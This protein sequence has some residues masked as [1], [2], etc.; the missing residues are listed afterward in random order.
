[1]VARGGIL[2]II[3]LIVNFVFST[4]AHAGDDIELAGD[5]IAI[6][7]PIVAGATSL[8]KDDHKGAIEF[9]ESFLVTLATTYTLKYCVDEK[10]P[11]GA[12]HSFPSSHSSIAFSGASF[13]KNIMVGDMVFPH[14]LQHH[15]LDGAVSNQTI[16]MF[17]ML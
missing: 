14:M 4:P 17:T 15:L 2:L 7:L 6:L 3:I 8:Y 13:Y 11:N 5:I 9:S 1:M 16:I 10:R 12:S